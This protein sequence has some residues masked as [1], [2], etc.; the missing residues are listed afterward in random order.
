LPLQTFDKL[1][2]FIRHLKT[3]L[4]LIH[5]LNGDERITEILQGTR[6]VISVITKMEIKCFSKLTS[7][8]IDLIDRLIGD[9]EVLELSSDI[10]NVAVEFRKKFNLKL[11]DA[12]IAASSYCTNIPLL[13]YDAAFGRLEEMDVV[14]LEQ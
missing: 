7:V 3:I 9:C 13:T 12:I 10:Q 6:L 1:N 4:V 14:I 8:D 5:L 2:L 11:P